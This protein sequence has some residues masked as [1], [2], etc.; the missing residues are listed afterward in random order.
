MDALAP[1]PFWRGVVARLPA[2]LK[3]KPERYAQVVAVSAQGKVLESLQHQ[4]PDSYSPVTSALEHD[5]WLYLGSLS[6]AGLARL[7]LDARR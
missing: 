7:K 1:H 4:A 3:P 6:H 5:G 2:A